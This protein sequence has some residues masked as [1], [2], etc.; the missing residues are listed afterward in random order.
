MSLPLHYKEI[1]DPLI[2]NVFLNLG[3]LDLS[4]TRCGSALQSRLSPPKFLFVVLPLAHPPCPFALFWFSNFS[5]PVS[6]SLN[7]S[8]PNFWGATR[9]RPGT[10]KKRHQRT[11][12]NTYSIHCLHNAQIS[13]LGKGTI[14]LASTWHLQGWLAHLN[15][16]PEKE[17]PALE[18]HSNLY[19][20]HA[21]QKTIALKWQFSQVL[22]SLLKFQNLKDASNQSPDSRY[23]VFLL[24]NSLFKYNKI[25]KNKTAFI[26]NII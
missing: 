26:P 21:I 6:I 9:V 8:L 12:R 17:I 22:S 24:L 4:K 18:V 20:L 7:R 3:C 25:D 13:W 15:W 2:L 14:S 1:L 11:H 23:H 5:L 10:T 16:L 19:L